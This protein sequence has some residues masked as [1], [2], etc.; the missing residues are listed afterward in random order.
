MR[1][2]NYTTPDHWLS[3]KQIVTRLA[4][5]IVEL[6]A[7]SGACTEDDI[8]AMGFAPEVIARHL[9][10]AKKLARRMAPQLQGGLA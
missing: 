9:D 4:D 6:A 3:P 5:R 2:P 10:A 7:Q 8:K 1:N